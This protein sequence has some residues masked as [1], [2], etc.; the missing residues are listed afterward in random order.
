MMTVLCAFLE[1]SALTIF[2][3]WSSDVPVCNKLLGS[4]SSPSLASCMR[5]NV[6]ITVLDELVV[7]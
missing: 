3:R 6:P 7:A 5:Y 4:E 2:D 1:S